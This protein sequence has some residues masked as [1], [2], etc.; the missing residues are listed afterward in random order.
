VPTTYN[1]V[2]ENELAANGFNVVIYANQLLRAAFPA[3]QKVALGILKNGRSAEIDS[4][5]M[6]IKEILRLIPGTQ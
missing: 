5:L 3:M 6:G 2:T 4:D 1:S